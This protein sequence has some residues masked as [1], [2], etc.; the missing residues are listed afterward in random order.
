MEGEEGRG[1]GL[2]PGKIRKCLLMSFLSREP[3]KRAPAQAPKLRDGE[4]T[5]KHEEPVEGGVGVDPPEHDDGEGVAGQPEDADG[6][7]EHPVQPEGGGRH[8]VPVL[9]ERLVAPVL[10]R[11]RKGRTGGRRRCR[12]RRCRRGRRRRRRSGSSKVQGL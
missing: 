2:S 5:E 8:H 11:G 10:D 6:Q 1:G 12:R 4:L 3:E 9:G 7:D